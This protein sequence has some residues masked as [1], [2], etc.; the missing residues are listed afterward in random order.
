[1]YDVVER[2]GQPRI[3][4]ELVQSHTLRQVIAQDGPLCP[5]AVAEIGMAVLKG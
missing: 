3:M 2:A 1:M 4:L 5:L